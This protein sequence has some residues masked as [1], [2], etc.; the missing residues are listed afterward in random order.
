VSVIVAAV[1]VVVVVIIVKGLGHV[2]ATSYLILPRPTRSLH[3]K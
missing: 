1:F 3:R 2:L